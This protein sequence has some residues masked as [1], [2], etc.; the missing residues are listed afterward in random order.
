MADHFSRTSLCVVS[1]MF[2]SLMPE[3]WFF[4]LRRLPPTLADLLNVYIGTLDIVACH[5][6]RYT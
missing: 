6:N 1:F 4:M 5:F 3:S 2:T